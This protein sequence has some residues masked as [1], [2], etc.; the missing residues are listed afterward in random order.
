M[1]NVNALND[2]NSGGLKRYVIVGGGIAGVSC[3]E[4]LHQLDPTADIHVISSS[5]LIKTVT[6]FKQVSRAMEE[7]E[8]KE[9]NIAYLTQ[10]CP[11]V[12]VQNMAVTAFHPKSKFLL[13]ADST[14]IT[15]DK[16]CICTGA[17]P[18]IIVKDHPR[19]LGI[20]DTESVKVS[21]I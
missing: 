12:Q 10:I 15:Y 5:P 2:G 17:V 9:R 4:E 20:R 18:K 13:L 6:N 8:V 1:A 3:A 16:L 19:V 21:A 14:N 7:F 11:N